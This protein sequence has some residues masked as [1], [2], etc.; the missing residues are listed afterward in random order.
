MGNLRPS[1]PDGGS[2]VSSGSLAPR[3]DVL[4]VHILLQ[5]SAECWWKYLISAEY[6]PEEKAP[7]Y[8]QFLFP[9]PSAANAAPRRVRRPVCGIGHSTKFRSTKDR[10]VHSQSQFRAQRRYRT[11]FTPNYT[12]RGVVETPSA[13]AI[14]GNHPVECG[15]KFSATLRIARMDKSYRLAQPPRE[16]QLVCLISLDWPAC[17]YSLPTFECSSGVIPAQDGP[18]CCSYRPAFRGEANFRDAGRRG[19]AE[20]PIPTG[21]KRRRKNVYT[22]VWRPGPIS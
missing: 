8:P 21:G 16:D 22:G 6:S 14:P 10:K 12:N 15:Q 20:L 5:V 17:K 4:I 13:V 19:G 9:A 2:A 1:S 7:Q 3:L 11:G 18:S